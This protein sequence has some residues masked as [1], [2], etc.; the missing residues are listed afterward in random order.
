MLLYLNAGT[1]ATT[2][3]VRSGGNEIYSN[4]RD[5]STYTDGR[6]LAVRPDLQRDYAGDRSSGRENDRRRCENLRA[7]NEAIYRQR[8]RIQQRRRKV[9]ARRRALA[10]LFVSIVAVAVPFFS[11]MPWGG[12]DSIHKTNNDMWITSG[13]VPVQIIPPADQ[14]EREYIP[15]AAEVAALAKMVYGE[16]R[17]IRSDAEKAACIWCVLNRV[18]DPRFPDTV[19]EVVSAPYQFAG[20]SP[21]HPVTPELEA[22]AADVLTRYHAEKNGQQDAGRT[23]PADYLFF[24]GDGKRNHFTKEWNGEETY[25]WTL[26]SPYEE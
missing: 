19:I 22:L 1:G 21:F 4:R 17:G 14:I 15:D 18:D 10:I 12:A 8:R 26:P 11:F 7:E 2:K 3:E 24:T 9:K 5:G 20:Y 23:L 13:D 6:I 16:A 25:Q